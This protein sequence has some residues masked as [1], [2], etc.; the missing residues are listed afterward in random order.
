MA[1]HPGVFVSEELAE[2]GWAQRDLAMVLGVPEQTVHKLL[3]QQL[4][5]TAEMSLVLGKAFGISSGL[6]LG[7]QRRYDISRLPEASDAIS[8]RAEIIDL[9]P[10]REMIK[11]GWIEGG[12]KD[13]LVDEVV[14]FKNESIGS[15]E[16]S[17]AARRAH[18]DEIPKEQRAWLYRV[19]QI[20]RTMVVPDYSPHALKEAVEEMKSL[21]S[22]PEH[23]SHVPRLLQDAG[24]RFVVVEALRGGK[25][26]GA[27]LWIDNSPV[28]GMSLR[29]DRIDNFWFTL[30]HEIEHV[31]NGD[32]MDG[33]KVDT[34]DELRMLGVDDPEDERLANEVSADFCVDSNLMEQ[35]FRKKDPFFSRRDIESFADVAKTHPGLIVGQLQKRTER[36][37]FLRAL[38]DPVR[39][40]ILPAAT[41]D[42]W[43]CVAL[44]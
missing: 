37:N 10:V 24:V 5:V 26:E 44:L 43:G 12:D 14:R 6:M 29:Y 39:Q 34:A 4:G 8:D 33:A 41:Y 1:R 2:R 3:K 25:I 15:E 16:F 40:F 30:R 31:L 20:A 23:V 21:R 36:W 11:R 38:L 9:F 19:S 32:G 42:G 27:C 18:A 28:I 22:Q 13:R 35:F 17:F 7:L